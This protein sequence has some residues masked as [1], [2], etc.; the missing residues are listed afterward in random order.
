[1]D[2]QPTMAFPPRTE[3]IENVTQHEGGWWEGDDP[4]G[5]RGWFPGKCKS[6][7]AAPDAAVGVYSTE[8]HPPL[9]SPPVDPADNFVEVV[10]SKP[11]AKSEAKAPPPKPAPP[12][13]AGVGLGVLESWRAGA[14]VSC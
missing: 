4:N 14:C 3:I 11:K 7:A 5:K 10:K 2:T 1:M 8:T 6:R 13:A 12:A 9:P